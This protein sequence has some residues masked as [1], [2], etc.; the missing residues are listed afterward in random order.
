MDQRQAQIRERAGLEESLLN[1]DF[2]E[3]LRRWGTP[4]LMVAAAA[5][6]GYS[7]WVRHEKTTNDKVDKAF[8]EL[9]QASTGANASP[10]SLQAVA[11]TYEGVRA[12]PM[13][14]RLAAADAYLD[15]VRRKM[16]IGAAIEVDEATRRPTGKL[17]RPED[18][19]TEEDRKAYLASAG[20]LYRQVFDAAKTSSGNILTRVNAM[21]GLAAVAECNEQW[22][23]AKDWYQQITSLV[24]GTNYDLHGKVAQRRLLAVDGL[25]DVPPAPLDAS[26]PKKPAPPPP[27]VTVT[28]VPAPST[29]VPFAPEPAPQGGPGEAPKTEPA[30]PADAPKTEPA[31]APKP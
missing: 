21:Y 5:A 12:V 16:K 28:P 25:K 8:A 1:Q 10:D 13:L 17:A 9:A 22:D 2:I 30:K 29:P 11:G 4:I 18:A 3:W 27:P 15:A 26:V 20:D 6:V 24:E 14:A 7:L 31:P 19:L 23:Q